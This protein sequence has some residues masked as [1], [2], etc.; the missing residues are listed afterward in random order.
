MSWYHGTT[1]SIKF[2]QAHMHALLSSDCSQLNP[3]HLTPHLA[4]HLFAGKSDDSL[5]SD[6]S[7]ESL[8]TSLLLLS[9][10]QNFTE[11]F[12][13]LNLIF[14]TFDAIANSHGIGD[15]L[16]LQYSWPRAVVSYTPL[17]PE[18]DWNIHIGK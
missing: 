15:T 11:P 7:E 1:P 18:T 10:T 9:S 16:W 4:S 5:V 2:L 6:S 12:S 17:C 8:S 13:S 14:C 3:T